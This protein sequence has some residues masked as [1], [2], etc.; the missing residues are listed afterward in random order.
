METVLS[1]KFNLDTGCVEML[2]RHKSMISIKLY[3]GRK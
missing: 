1:C 2:L 3:S